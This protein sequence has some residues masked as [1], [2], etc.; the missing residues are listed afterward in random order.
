MM[1]K[2]PESPLNPTLVAK[3]AAQILAAIALVIAIGFWGLST[4]RIMRAGAR[5]T[6]H[7]ISI[8]NKSVEEES[9]GNSGEVSVATYEFLNGARTVHGSVTGSEGS[10][11]VG[12]TVTVEYNPS[13]PVENHA[14]GDNNPVVTFF[15]FLVFGGSVAIY[16][17]ELGL[18]VL[19]SCW[20]LWRT[21]GLFAAHQ[22]EG[23]TDEN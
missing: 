12:E 18:P 16:A 17:F 5:T 8:A 13:N 22:N 15:L 20:T 6:A 2:S 19:R 3:A 9:T 21:G 23:S 7:I 1:S 10:W 4:W 11:S 14:T